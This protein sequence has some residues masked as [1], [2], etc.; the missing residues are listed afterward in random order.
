MSGLSLMQTRTLIDKLGD[1]DEEITRVCRTGEAVSK[2]AGK[3]RADEVARLK[4][5][6]EA[7]AACQ[8]HVRMAKDCLLRFDGY[9]NAVKPSIREA[10]MHPNMGGKA[11]RFFDEVGRK[12]GPA[13]EH[14]V[15]GLAEEAVECIGRVQASLKALRVAEETEARKDDAKLSCKALEKVVAA[16]EKTIE[17]G[18]KM[19]E[20][21]G[22]PPRHEEREEPVEEAVEEAVEEG[23]EG[24]AVEE[25]EMVEG[26]T[27]HGYNLT[28]KGLPPAFLENIQ[29]KKDEAKAKKDDDSDDEKKSDKKAALPP[30]FLENIKKKKDEAKGKKDD[31]DD[32]SDKKAGVV[33]G[34]LLVA[35]SE[36]PDPS[37]K[38]EEPVVGKSAGHG[39]QITAPAE[40]GYELTV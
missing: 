17:K 19:A 22:L 10:L 12:A 32:K 34:Y 36:D 16:A 14:H 23:P 11:A 30:E 1:L 29:K 39:Y 4:T 6:M 2:R 25:A 9:L 38:D 24:E 26:K 7:A 37:M 18:V 27:A 28:A 5:A 3:G 13:M 8:E 15:G 35:D 31:E 21:A 33:H 40:H 20:G